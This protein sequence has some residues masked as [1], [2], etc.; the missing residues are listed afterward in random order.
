MEVKGKKKSIQVNIDKELSQDVDSVLDSLGV[1]PT[2][3]IT[4]LYKKIAEKGDI[5]FSLGL[6]ETDREKAINRLAKAAKKVP[7]K[8]LSTMDEVN[9]WLNEEDK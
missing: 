3:L 5:P 9:K 1:N 7:T 2:V 4:A 8:Q 6:T